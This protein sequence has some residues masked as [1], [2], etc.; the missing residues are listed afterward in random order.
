METHPR[1]NVILRSL[2]LQPEIE[3]DIQE[4]PYAVDDAF[5]ISSDGLTG[6]C[7]KPEVLEVV[8]R[9]FDRPMEAA[10]DL[11]DRANKHGGHDNITVQIARVLAMTVEEGQKRL[12]RGGPEWQHLLDETGK[13]EPKR[14]PSDEEMRANAPKPAPAT[15]SGSGV[16]GTMSP[17]EVKRIREQALANAGRSPGGP[18]APPAPPGGAAPRARTG[19][20]PA[21]PTFAKKSL[22]EHILYWTSRPAVWLAWPF[23]ALCRRLKRS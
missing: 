4:I 19:T 15:E 14:L 10:I 16:T 6:Q 22:L 17:E 8:T 2:G 21:K 5:V 13:G 7:K 1:K 3:V 23:V 20:A 9:L 18:P 11:V 12:E